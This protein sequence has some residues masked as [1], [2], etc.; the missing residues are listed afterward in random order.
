MGG[1]GIEGSASGSTCRRE[2]ASRMESTTQWIATDPAPVS[3]R[4]SRLPGTE[5]PEASVL[6]KLAMA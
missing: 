5:E 2:D 6:M 4:R 1:D 3:V